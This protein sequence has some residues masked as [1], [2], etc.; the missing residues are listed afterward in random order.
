MTDLP[1]ALVPELCRIV[2][3]STAP[4]AAP[5]SDP[6]IARTRDTWNAADFGRIAVGYAAGAAAFVDRLSPAAGE[7]VLDVA[8]GTGNLSLPAARHGAIVTGVD[9]AP[10]LLDTA[11]RAA[12]AASLD[13]QFDVGAAEALPYA[14][15]AFDTVLSMFGVMFAARPER[16]LAELVRV[17]RRGGRIALANWAPD[18]F[19]G[20]MLRAHTALVPP[21]PGAPSPLAWGDETA[22]RRRLETHAAA[23]RAGRFVP[24]TI[25]LAFPLTPRGVVELF[26]GCYGPSVKTFAALDAE[27]RARLATELHRLWDGRNHA[28]NGATSVAAE[29]LEVHIDLA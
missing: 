8:C 17:T 14:D 9:I 15:G 5:P 3:G 29:Y 12:A 11:R 7:S 26:R 25:D 6:L 27:G 20:A 22:M 4:P 1:H 2:T 10:A 18:G 19:V 23:I 24:R 21:A 28:A 13:I 16:A